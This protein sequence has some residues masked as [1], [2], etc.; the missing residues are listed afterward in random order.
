MYHISN[1]TLREVL[2]DPAAAER[3]VWDLEMPRLA[4]D[5]GAIG[6]LARQALT[7]TGSSRL[8]HVTASIRLAHVL[9][10]QQRYLE[11]DELFVQALD[12]AD[13]LGDDL[14]RAFAHQH[15]GKSLF[16]Q[17]RFSAA[18]EQFSTALRIRESVPAPQDQIASSR[19]ALTA[20]A[21][22]IL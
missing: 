2:D 17:G 16:D 10:W 3:R 20:A 1:E 19:P 15:Y 8:H 18:V 13:A 9:H 11:A 12:A 4:D 6:E 21:Q 7:L 22:R 5:T 14:L